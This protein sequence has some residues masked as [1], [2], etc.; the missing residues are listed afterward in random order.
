M[1][2]QGEPEL[3]QR[4]AAETVH[5]LPSPRGQPTGNA[6]VRQDY[7][8]ALAERLPAVAWSTDDALRITTSRGRGLAA[9]GLAPDEV[10]GAS[11]FDYFHTTDESFPPIAAHRRALAGEAVAYQVDWQGRSYT[12]LVEPL[13]LPG[14]AVAG[15]AGVAF[16]LA[17]CAV[18]A[19][20]LEP[21]WEADLRQGQ[22]LT[23]LGRLVAGI[24][25]DFNNLLT[26]IIGLSDL[27]RSRLAG[28]DRDLADEVY[29]AGERA[30]ALT[31]QL[32][33]FSRHEP[34]RP[35]VLDLNAVV[36][37]MGGLLR[38]LLGEDVRLEWALAP[39]LGQVRADRGQLEQVLLNLA[40][41]AR[42]AMPAGGRLTIET[43]NVEPTGPAPDA[44]GVGQGRYVLL[45]VSDTGV[46]MTEAVQAR[47]FEPF[48][49]TKEPG[50]GTGLGLATVHQIVEQGGGAI[51]VR[52]A[53]G[54]GATFRV[55]LPRV[56]A[57]TAGP[58]SP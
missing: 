55:Y 56:A 43:A 52:S 4:Q 57:E 17:G 5:D 38:R 58:P 21:A 9:L 3:G 12:A 28:Q 36:A 33:A 10:V 7:W 40:V 11:L 46:G 42:D 22:K 27:L 47:L 24:V 1:V 51:A 23:I 45:S 37:D 30:A 29:K 25:H 34:V 48:F 41:N 53:P 19:H 54:R 32:L 18:A 44:P 13:C 49:T 14:G 16:D 35:A 6:G 2:E 39:D 8:W 15:C 31:R 50:K 26:A 20:A